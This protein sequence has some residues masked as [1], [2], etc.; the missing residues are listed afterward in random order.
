MKIAA[1]VM[2]HHRP[3]CLGRLL[4]R[5]Q[6]D[7]W[8]RYLHVDAKADLAPF[9][10]LLRLVNPVPRRMAVYWGTFSQVEVAV[11]L[12]RYALED[13]ENTH[14]YT[15]TGQDYP[16]KPDSEIASAIARAAYGGNFIT[17]RRMPTRDKPLSRLEK[18]YYSR[19]S[20]RWRK[21]L[22]DVL[23]K[24]RVDRHLR[25]LEPFAGSAMW[26]LNRRTG[27]EMIDFLDDNPWY[28]AAF[29]HTKCP[30]EMF[31]QTLARHLG[32][33][34]DG[35]CPTRSFWIQGRSNPELITPAIL[36]EIR[37]DWH[38]MARKFDRY[39]PS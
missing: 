21:K 2:A 7:L 24:R 29:R 26:V 34:V 23:P 25:G 4:S 6:G 5:L 38:F 28:S 10:H 14:F 37:G 31:F 32:V 3:D 12:L 22:A 11:A 30:D 18:R 8:A 17:I 16:I 15:V 20:P 19:L 27:Q 1:L 35:G 9:T 13:R 33:D 36:K 39:Y